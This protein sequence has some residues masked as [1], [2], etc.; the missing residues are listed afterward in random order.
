MSYTQRSKFSGTA[1]EITILAYEI[2]VCD[3]VHGNKRRF[4]AS[5]VGRQP[6]GK[7]DGEGIRCK[8]RW[9]NQLLFVF[10]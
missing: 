10:P 9:P 6:L 5:L 8:S 2:F 4:L 1:T 7:M 3:T